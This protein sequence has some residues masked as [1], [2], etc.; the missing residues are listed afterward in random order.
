MARNRCG[1]LLSLILLYIQKFILLPVSTYTLSM[2]D[3]RNLSAMKIDNYTW[4]TIGLSAIAGMR[5]LSAPALL[6]HALQKSPFLTLESS[7][8]RYLQ[9]EP[10]AT[11]LKVMAA[12]E[13]AGDKI[14]G[15]PDRIIPPILLSRAASGALVGATL[16]TAHKGKV[17]QGALIGA[18][19]AV[20]ATYLSFYLRKSLTE[21][22]RLPDA[23]FAALEDAIVL[24]G[25][26]A[27]IKP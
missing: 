12:S 8:L 18:A 13:M 23:A 19:V 14:P 11:G 24:T 9:S 3:T 4:K 1:L 26:V 20:A 5:S 22:T 7:P 15:I 21:N 27:I 10:V 16:Y 2:L 6:S 17:V 25:G